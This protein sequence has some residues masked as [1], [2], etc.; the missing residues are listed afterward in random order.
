MT[1]RGRVGWLGAGH[2]VVRPPRTFT[3]ALLDRA[4]AKDGCQNTQA[5]PGATERQQVKARVVRATI[6][7]RVV[8]SAE[9]SRT[10]QTW[11]ALSL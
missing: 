8:T 5:G 10:N 4:D 9:R 11:V 3:W 1:V 6:Y 7:T 2:G